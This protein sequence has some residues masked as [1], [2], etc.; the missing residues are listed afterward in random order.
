M[1]YLNEL[2]LY[3]QMQGRPIK[4][5]SICPSPSTV[6]WQSTYSVVA[7]CTASTSPAWT[8]DILWGDLIDMKIERARRSGVRSRLLLAARKLARSLIPHSHSRFWRN[9]NAWGNVS[10]L[11]VVSIWKILTPLS[12]IS[13]PMRQ[14][15]ECNSERAWSMKLRLCCM[16]RT[17][18]W[19]RRLL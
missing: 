4:S 7:R 13:R 5:T 2:T 19:W 6:S 11:R 15:D 8:L 18:W 9:E 10:E 17:L 16:V 3:G 12:A 1:G 14:L